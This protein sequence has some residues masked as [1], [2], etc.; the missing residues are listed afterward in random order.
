M[1]PIQTTPSSSVSKQTIGCNNIKQ[2]A[3]KNIQHSTR[4]K[5]SNAIEMSGFIVDTVEF[6]GAKNKYHNQWLLGSYP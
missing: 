6:P 3:Y 4:I 5:L 2:P 1:K